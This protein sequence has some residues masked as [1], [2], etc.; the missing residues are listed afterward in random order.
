MCLSLGAFQ[1]YLPLVGMA[2]VFGVLA[3]VDRKLVQGLALIICTAIIGSLL[4]GFL[5]DLR[6]G[7]EVRRLEQSITELQNLMG[8][9]GGYPGK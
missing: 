3:V 9:P 1:L 4:H 6:H 8:K 7:D 5:F 2:L